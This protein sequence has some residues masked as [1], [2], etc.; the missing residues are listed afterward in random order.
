MHNSLCVVVHKELVEVA[1]QGLYDQAV[2]GNLN[3][4]VDVHELVGL[5]LWVDTRHDHLCDFD[6]S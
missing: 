4:G 6:R 2:K 3:D 1:A 5:E